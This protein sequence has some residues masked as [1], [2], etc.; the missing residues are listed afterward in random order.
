MNAP[1]L[2]R[3]LATRIIEGLRGRGRIVVVLGGTSAL[4]R[5][6]D[7]AVSA[8]IT[9]LS[10]RFELEPSSEPDQSTRDALTLLAAT[11]ARTVLSSEHLEDVFADSAIV[12]REERERAETR[13]GKRRSRH[14]GGGGPWR[15][16]GQAR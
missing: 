9:P 10:E 14:G 11:V 12:E 16:Q 2:S 5:L 3:R 1:N 13:V 4:V 8:F 15:S 7:D 6:V